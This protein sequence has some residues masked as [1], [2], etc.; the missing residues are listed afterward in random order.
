LATGGRDAGWAL[1]VTLSHRQHAIRR[2]TEFG[3]NIELH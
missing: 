3:N 1:S 2:G